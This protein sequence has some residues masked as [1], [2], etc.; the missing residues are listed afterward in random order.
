MSSSLLTYVKGDLFSSTDSLVHC[1]SRD[2]R[3][4]KGIAVRFKNAFGH[5]DELRAQNRSV[6]QVAYLQFPDRMIFNLVTKDAYYQ[7]PT[8]ASIRTA[9]TN[10]RA[11]CQ[12]FKIT[13]LSMPRIGC[14]LDQ[15]DWPTVEAIIEDIFSDSDIHITIYYY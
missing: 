9:L 3:M 4:G 7:K 14:G 8:Y 6:G 15:L 12:Y 10:L 5:I 1:V 13:K 2:L 11:L